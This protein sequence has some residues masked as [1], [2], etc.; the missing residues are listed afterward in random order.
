MQTI[1]DRL[2]KAFTYLKLEGVVTT[3]EDLSEKLGYDKA[4][5]SQAFNGSKKQ[6]TNHFIS[7]FCKKFAQISEDWIT[8]GKGDMI[9]NNQQIGNISNSAVIGANVSGNGN[10]ITPNEFEEMIKLQKGYQ[11]LLKK[12]DE[13]I[14][15][16]LRVISKLTNK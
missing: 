11:D 2:K 16:L 4:T 13:H 5:I 6:L 12:K 7:N 15:E 8:E 10:R 9:K 1:E 3:Q 14:S